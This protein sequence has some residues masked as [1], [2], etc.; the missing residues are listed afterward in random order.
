M[1]SSQGNDSDDVIDME[2]VQ[3][4]IIWNNYVQANPLKKEFLVRQQM[5]QYDQGFLPPAKKSNK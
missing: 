1:S 2:A 4:Q 3:R 5:R